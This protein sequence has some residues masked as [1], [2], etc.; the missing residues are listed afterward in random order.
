[1]W[2]SQQTLGIPGSEVPRRW[3]LKKDGTYSGCR[4][5]Y[6]Y[7]ATAQQMLDS[8]FPECRPTSAKDMLPFNKSE[9]FTSSSKLRTLAFTLLFEP[10]FL[11]GSQNFTK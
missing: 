6:T 3:P 7:S 1:V 2:L 8:F 9:I 10:C 11:Y 5:L 4:E